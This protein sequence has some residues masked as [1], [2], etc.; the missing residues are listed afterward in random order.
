MRKR[1]EA[2]LM[3]TSLKSESSKNKR[4]C[5]RILDFSLKKNKITEK[6]INLAIDFQ[7]RTPLI[8]ELTAY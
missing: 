5:I 7:I 4:V 8:K 1:F 2:L 3:E 6:L